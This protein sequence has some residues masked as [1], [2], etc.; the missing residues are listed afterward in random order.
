MFI[1]H[2]LDLK[3]LRFFKELESLAK[4]QAALEK[5]G[6]FHQHIV[7]SEEDFATLQGSTEEIPGT[8]VIEVSNISQGVDS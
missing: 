3:A 7:M 8:V 1:G 2:P 4:P 6:R 5:S